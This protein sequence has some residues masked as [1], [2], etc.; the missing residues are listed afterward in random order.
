MT[1]LFYANS[2]NLEKNT[3][4]KQLIKLSLFVRQIRFLSVQW[5]QSAPVGL[6]ESCR[7]GQRRSLDVPSRVTPT[8]FCLVTFG[9]VLSR[10]SV[11]A[12]DYSFRLKLKEHCVV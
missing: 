11:V 4:Y 2:S 5:S 7:C 3:G 1:H 10:L 9:Q 6:G 8:T 12:S